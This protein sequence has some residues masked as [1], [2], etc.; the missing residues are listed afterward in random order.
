MFTRSMAPL[1]L[2]ATLFYNLFLPHG[3]QSFE[4]VAKLSATK[5]PEIV[6]QEF[7]NDW[8]RLIGDPNGDG[9]VDFSI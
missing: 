7:E 4:F 5:A 1:F 8:F 6:I 2:K 3:W 9:K